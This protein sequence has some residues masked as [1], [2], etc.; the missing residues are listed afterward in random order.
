MGDREE[1]VA[2][3]RRKRLAHYWQWYVGGEL[4]QQELVERFL[5]HTAARDDL[6]GE[7]DRLAPE[8]REVVRDYFRHHRLESLPNPP[9]IGA[10]IEA[11][12]LIIRQIAGRL[13]EFLQART[14]L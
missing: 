8:Y 6:A 14:E 5:H 1:L 13:V 4:S 9:M 11:N 7:W 10:D 2:L 3:A 12:G